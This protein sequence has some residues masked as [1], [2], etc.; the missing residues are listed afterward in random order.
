MKTKARERGRRRRRRKKSSPRFDGEPPNFCGAHSLFC[1]RCCCSPKRRPEAWTFAPGR[2]SVSTEV[3]RVVSLPSSPSGGAATV[4]VL[5]TTVLLAGRGEAAEFSVLHH[6][7]DDPVDPWVTTDGL[8]VR[9]DEDDFKVLVARVLADPVRVEDSQRA[10]LSACSFLG[11]GPEGSGKLELGDTHGHR[12]T[13]ADTLGDR[14][15]TAATL[16][17]D[18]VDDVTLLCLV[19]KTS[20]LVWPGWSRRP[21]DGRE[22]TVL[23]GPHTEEEP[24]NVRLLTLVKLFEVLVGTHDCQ[25][26]YGFGLERKDTA[27]G[28]V[29]ERDKVPRIVSK[30]KSSRRK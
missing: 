3:H 30:R 9:V 8:V 21:V 24:E 25:K 11:L 4:A 26:L 15:F 1:P 20:G 5:V 12:L 23:P 19:A 18:T 7:S 2:L 13:V 17:T 10:A 28:R 14:S 27:R 16:D 29:W 22:L 6:R